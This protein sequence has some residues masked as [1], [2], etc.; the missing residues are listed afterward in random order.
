[1]FYNAIAFNQNISNWVTLNVTNMSSMFQNATSFNQDLSGWCVSLIPSLPLNFN[2]NTPAW[3]LPK[4]IW[5][6]CPP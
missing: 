2:T 4:P 3:V 1:M 5:G 6:T